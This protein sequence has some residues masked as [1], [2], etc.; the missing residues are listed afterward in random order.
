MTSRTYENVQGVL[1]YVL[2][3]S[4]A[5]ALVFTVDFNNLLGANDLTTWGMVNMPIIITATWVVAGLTLVAKVW[6]HL[7]NIKRIG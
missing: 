4:G 1:S 3:I 2:L 6:G 7:V 5:L